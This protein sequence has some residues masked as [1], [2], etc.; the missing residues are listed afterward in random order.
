MYFHF[1]ATYF[2]HNIVLW[3]PEGSSEGVHNNEVLLYKSCHQVLPV[4]VIAVLM[5]GT[6]CVFFGMVLHKIFD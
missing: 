6:I 5:S 4:I 2:T 3:T 1:S